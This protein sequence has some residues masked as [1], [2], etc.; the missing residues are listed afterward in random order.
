MGARKDGGGAP[1]YTVTWSIL[2]TIRALTPDPRL[3][4]DS[5][6]PIRCLSGRLGYRHKS[7]D[8]VTVACLTAYLGDGPGSH[9]AADFHNRL[10]VWLEV[11][12]AVLVVAERDLLTRRQ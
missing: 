8:V 1:F 4:G 10:T 5:R 2:R 7:L 6:G 12:G 11:E 3:R 9:G